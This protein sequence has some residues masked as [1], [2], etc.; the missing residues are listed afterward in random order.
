MERKKMNKIV[1]NEKKY[2]LDALNGTE[3]PDIGFY[4]F[5]NLISKYY[6]A[7]CATVE[8]TIYNVDEQMK[9]LYKEEYLKEK[10]RVYISGIFKK[11]KEGITGI[12]D[13]EDVV[14]YTWD[15]CQVFKGETDQERKLL[16]SAYVIAHYMGC[17]GWLNTKTSKSIADWFEM[18]N[19][20]CT[21]SDRFLFLGEMKKKGLIETTK[22]CDNLNVKVN[23]LS[24]YFGETPVF[25]ITELENLGNLLI[26]TYKDGY[27]QCECG[28]LI[29]INSN[30]QTM[31]RFCALKNDQK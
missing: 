25:R 12:N 16:F 13:R 10:W 4:S 1:V 20:A 17:N 11:V 2:V 7:Q 9:K 26:A 8:E 29:K 14:V 27:K 3:K 30:R 23:M 18:A 5:L 24:D 31:C 21:S 19:V 22:K 28:R 15:M 6:A